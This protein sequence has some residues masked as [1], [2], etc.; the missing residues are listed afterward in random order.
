MVKE[1]KRPQA[2]TPHIN[3]ALL[4]VD[5]DEDVRR[6]RPDLWYRKGGTLHVVEVTVPY[7]TPSHRENTL[8]TRRREK[9][10][11]CEPLL[12]ALR[13]RPGA[14]AELHVIVVG[15]LGAIPKSTFKVLEKLA[16][17]SIVR[18]YAKRM[19]AAAILGSRLVYL[20]ARRPNQTTTNQGEAERTTSGEGD[21]DSSDTET[22]EAETT[23]DQREEDPFRFDQKVCEDMRHLVGHFLD[24]S[25]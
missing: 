14:A 17:T 16:P 20:D 12:T 1:G 3:S 8:E 2:L 22:R 21:T 6:L 13:R 23:V 25:L 19:T 24:D 10:E 5:E 11:K 7:A 9:L 18:R 4:E 15:S